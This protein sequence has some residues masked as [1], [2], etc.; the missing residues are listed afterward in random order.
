MAQGDFRKF[1]LRG[2]VVDM[3]V[4][5]IIGAAFATVVSA[6]VKDL[7]T[8][9]VAAVGGKP[10]FGGLSFTINHSH[11]LYGNFINAVISFVIMA[12]VVY[13]FVVVPVNQL[14]AR[15]H[16]PAPPAPPTT[17]AC[18]ECLSAVPLEARRC[19]Y[20]TSPLAVASTATP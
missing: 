16:P 5:I 18:P 17:R 14:A 19:A 15:F 8:P 7:L 11:F 12:A 20:C 3:A 10:T 4:G 2:N 13:Y 1:L 6:L 9:L